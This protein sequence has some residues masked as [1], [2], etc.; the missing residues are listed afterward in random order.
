VL[1]DFFDRDAVANEQ[2]G[3][4]ARGEQLDS[5]FLQFA[6]ELDDSGF[7]GNTEKCAADWVSQ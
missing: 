4:A 6:R 7:I 2:L 1:C 5:A 3:S